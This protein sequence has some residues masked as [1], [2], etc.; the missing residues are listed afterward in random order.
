ME[1]ERKFRSWLP[2]LQ[3]SLRLEACDIRIF[4]A[5]TSSKNRLVLLQM[6]AAWLKLAEQAEKNTQVSP[7]HETPEPRQDS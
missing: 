6:A 5:E 7:V 1:S 3:E 2:D 4:G